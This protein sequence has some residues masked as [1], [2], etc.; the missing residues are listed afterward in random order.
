M[1]AMP[2]PLVLETY[3]LFSIILHLTSNCLYVSTMWDK[4]AQWKGL[5]LRV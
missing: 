1:P 5:G 4:G 2:L 3:V